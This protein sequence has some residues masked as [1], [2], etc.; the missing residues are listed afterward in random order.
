MWRHGMTTLLIL[1]L[2]MPALAQTGGDALD[3][4]RKRQEVAAQA[5]EQEIAALISEAERHWSDPAKAVPLLEKALEKLGP[6]SP[7]SIARSADLK[8]RIQERIK[9]IQAGQPKK[10]EP[11]AVP[12]KSFTTAQQQEIKQELELIRKLQDEKK[13]DEANQVANRLFAKY[14][15]LVAADQAQA[16]TTMSNVVRDVDQVQREKARGFN[17]NMREIDKSSIPPSGD[18]QYPSK[19]DWKRITER[20][21]RLAEKNNPLTPREREILKKL[22]MLTRNPTRFKEAPLNEVIAYL[23][24]ELGLPIVLPRTTLQEMNL[25]YNTP[26]TVN[27]PNQV[28]RRTVLRTVLAD[29]GLTYI[30]KN[31]MI[32]IVSQARANQ[33]QVTRVLAVDSL[34]FGQNGWNPQALIDFIQTNIEPAS[35]KSGGGQGTITYYPPG[36]CLI[37]RNSAEVISKLDALR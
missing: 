20:A 26:V 13:F 11:A 21:K 30:V 37:I 14:P 34:L 36:R 19:E 4:A 3:E 24:Q 27:L 18:I 12:A 28:T 16:T 5:L 6:A 1:I 9:A 8:N 2:A 32:Q 7:L 22:D 15:T 35:W 17:D 25:E 29:L 10:E 33:E 31:E 23:E